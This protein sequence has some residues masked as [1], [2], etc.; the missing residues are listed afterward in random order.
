MK[1]KRVI[2]IG[3]V[4]FA[5]VL[6][7]MVFA[8]TAYA[9]DKNENAS[10]TIGSCK[11]SYEAY[12]GTLRISADGDG[13]MPD[14]NYYT[15]KKVGDHVSDV[16][17]INLKRFIK[18][19]DIGT[20]VKNIGRGAFYVGGATSFQSGPIKVYLPEGIE[21]GE[22]AFHRTEISSIN[23]EK[24]KKFGKS[25]FEQATLPKTIQIKAEDI[26]VQAF[27]NL[28][29]TEVLIIYGSGNAKIGSSAFCGCKNLK[30][31]YF[32]QNIKSIGQEA[33]ADSLK[34][35]YYY[36]AVEIPKTVT[37]IGDKAFD[38]E[39]LIILTTEGSA[40]DTYAQQNGIE[41]KYDCSF[42]TNYRD[43]D[44]IYD[45]N[46]KKLTLN[47]STDYVFQTGSSED[48]YNIKTPD[49]NDEYWQEFVNEMG[50]AVYSVVISD[51]IDPRGGF[52]E[53]TGGFKLFPNLMYV[54][55]VDEAK[56]INIIGEGA[57]SGLK[58]L[59]KVTLNEGME[60][61]GS[62]A[63]ADCTA[64]NEVNLNKN[65]NYI[66]EEAFRK[67]A[68]KS[69]D[70]GNEKFSKHA[71]IETYEDVLGDPIEIDP[72]IF[73][74][75]EYLQEVRLGARF[76]G[77]GC[78][79]FEDCIRLNKVE[80]TDENADV[81]DFAF[82]N[83]SA[84]ME[85]PIRRTL[86]HV[87]EQAFVGTGV[88]EILIPESIT[89]IGDMAFCYEDLG[90]AIRLRE[91]AKLYVISGSAGQAYAESNGIDH[92]V[93]VG[94]ALGEIDWRY[95][96]TTG[97]LFISG[98][99]EM[100]VFTA[101][102]IA[103]W[104]HYSKNM[105][106]VEI[107][108][109]ITTVSNKS[110]LAEAGEFINLKNVVI[111]E[112]VTKIGTR[113][114]YNCPLKTIT[115]PNPET[116]ISTKA[117]G[118]LVD[119]YGNE[120]INSELIIFC[121]EG[122]KAEAYAIENGLHYENSLGGGKTGDCTFTF[123][124]KTGRLTISGNGAMEDYTHSDYTP[125]VDFEDDIKCIVVEPG[126]TSV[127][128]HAFEGLMN[129]EKV[130]LHEGLKTLG[131]F[132]FAYD[133]KLEKLYVPPGVTNIGL[134]AF[135]HDI[136]ILIPETD[137][138]AIVQYCFD[139]KVNRYYAIEGIVGDCFYELNTA[140][141]SLTVSGK[142]SFECETYPWDKYKDQIK[143][144]RVE[145]GITSVA[146]RAFAGMTNL[147]DVYLNDYTVRTIGYG[148]FRGDF[149]LTSFTLP[150]DVTVIED[151]AFEECTGLES[152]NQQR[153]AL[154][155]IGRY[156]FRGCKN[157]R[158]FDFL[159]YLEEVGD[160][161]FADS[162]LES[163]TIPPS[164][165]NIGSR[166]FAGAKIKE[167]EIPKTVTDIGEKAF[168]YVNDSTKVEGFTIT[169]FE[170]SAGGRYAIEEGFN[171]IDPT[172]G[173]ISDDSGTQYGDVRWKFKESD[174]SLTISGEGMIPD[175]EEG[176]APW[177]I[178]RDNI[179]S[180]VIEDGITYVGTYAFYDLWKVKE[181]SIP[182]TVEQIMDFA[183]YGTMP[184]EINIPEGVR[185]IGVEAFNMTYANSITLPE[186]L[187]EIDSGAFLN[188]R[189]TSIIMPSTLHTIGDHAIGF[190]R[191]FG[192]TAWEPRYSE[193]PDY[194]YY[195]VYGQEGS[196][197]QQ[198]VEEYSKTYDHLRFEAFK[199]GDPEYINP[200]IMTYVAEKAPTKTAYGIKA[201]YECSHC[202][203]W[204]LDDE[205]YNLV[206][207]EYLRIAKIPYLNYSKKSLKAGVKVTLK[208]VN[209]TVKSWKSSAAAVAKV[210]SS[211]VVTAL[212]KGT[213]TIT[214]T[215]KTG[216]TLKCKITVTTN[217]TI[218]VGGKK[219]KAS[220]TY[221]VKKGKYLTVKIT[222][223]AASAANVYSTS[224]KTVAKVTT[225]SKKTSTVKIKGLKVGKA[226]V[227]IKVNGVAFKIKVKVIK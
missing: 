92:E 2:R 4:F 186:G 36:Y 160:Y 142:G 125:W 191:I 141:Y 114:F 38:D 24:V 224:N 162:G 157:L 107:G 96:E 128:T 147:T 215:L 47:C 46:T 122:S 213:A 189:E 89:D 64:L 181:I 112:A 55:I 43:A 77:F 110:F 63:F 41:V 69:L 187:E 153:W 88:N 81:D 182:E 49:E 207:A 30:H 13:I 17:W 117:L 25:S 156:A 67:C 9:E 222:G 150:E 145:Y 210:S 95:N 148:A 98:N 34:S 135:D 198:Y 190:D 175:Y 35:S 104:T 195:I 48:I 57:F 221:K 184:N 200:H 203:L 173:H 143:S 129:L 80:Y 14:F 115:I 90:N 179:K 3:I 33:F 58:R 152:F 155:K 168:G 188:S 60:R 109:S 59:Y 226:N 6:A 65:L 29:G 7:L 105:T 159:R 56:T 102:N 201:H 121:K 42:Y 111:G 50:D 119:K 97:A 220:T 146:P 209:C 217:P 78:N 52:K 12:S 85:F 205:G 71:G 120:S 66:G 40:A 79:M 15:A 208:G 169:A 149:S 219:F 214:A 10:G 127:G 140:I 82:K 131:T 39:G 206:D 180:I 223:R 133:T 166:A 94:G 185:Y 106:S 167:V 99:G 163:I 134:R 100:P 164:L 123:N 216:K 19:I 108:G 93:N 178:H 21:I 8:A 61:I 72:G 23:I 137:N 183:F 1:A 130:I 204:F 5:L 202:D 176:Q 74:G 44:W 76:S 192:P 87:G 70:I 54:T 227:T 91:D 172:C 199:P 154:T 31:V 113:A 86:S 136:T 26:G 28:N 218:T 118:Y 20:G 174:G 27:Q 197:A 68:F 171:W 161:A 73:K 45:W 139:Y 194:V 196:V 32:G 62:E 116:T 177:Y 75:C 211:G 101:Q 144:V 103:P 53:I 16:P 11:W 18:R 193:D 51:R 170:N 83:C 165:Y 126:V 132:A 124:P 138:E 151:R 212:K 225:T 84:L 158:E 22:E 37:S